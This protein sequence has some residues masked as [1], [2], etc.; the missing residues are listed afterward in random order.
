MLALSKVRCVGPHSSNI[1]PALEP[2]TNTAKTAITARTE[3][4]E[5]TA[6]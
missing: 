5:N 3:A 6:I 4:A 1:I 2:A